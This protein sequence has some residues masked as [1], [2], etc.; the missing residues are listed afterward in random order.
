MRVGDLRTPAALIDLD[1]LERNVARMGATAAHLGV[2]LRPHV[3]THKTL[4]GARIQVRG[5]FGGITVSTLA[6]A[7]FFAAGG[8]SDITYAVP[9]APA[10]TADAGGDRELR[11]RGRV[12]LRAPH[13]DRALRRAAGVAAGRRR[14][15]ALQGPRAGARGPRLR[16]RHRVRR[17]WR[18]AA[19]LARRVVV[20]GARSR[21]LGAAAADGFV[22]DRVAAADRA[23]PLLPR[24]VALR[25]LRG[26]ARR[27]GGR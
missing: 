5:Q 7:V 14:A 20:P 21:A 25:A 16:V 9:V 10:K 26:G 2:R 12:V 3:K 6:E 24:R 13:R 4:E 17:R 22:P 8:F 23:Q 1:A 18:A 11:A 19:G 27:P 15:R